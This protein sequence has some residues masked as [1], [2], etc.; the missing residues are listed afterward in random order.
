[1]EAAAR[2]VPARLPFLVPP[3]GLTCEPTGS[4]DAGAAGTTSTQQPGA[5]PAGAWSAAPQDPDVNPGAQEPAARPANPAHARASGLPGMSRLE[6]PVSGARQEAFAYVSRR[7]L[8]HRPDGA[9]FFHLSRVE[10]Q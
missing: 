8:R 4:S 10:W 6:V 1:M 3:R 5:T 7:F 9:R 2:Q